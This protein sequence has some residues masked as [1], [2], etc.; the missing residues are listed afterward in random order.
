MQYLDP[1]E[2]W[3]WFVRKTRRVP[4]V[5][6]GIALAEGP[7]GVEVRSSAA[8]TVLLT[9]LGLGL[10]VVGY[11]VWPHERIGAYAALVLGGLFLVGAL[12]GA[13][14]R[15]GVKWDPY[16][17]A[18]TLCRG[19]VPFVRTLELP[20][21][22]LRIELSVGGDDSA[23]SSLKPGYS[24][25]SLG[26]ADRPGLA[27]LAC[28]EERGQLDAVVE[29]LGA[30]LGAPAQDH[31]HV[32]VVTGDGEALEVDA[33]PLGRDAATARSVRLSFLS[34][35]VAVFRS[36]GGG[37][38]RGFLMSG[39]A[40][41]A[42]FA[43][44]TGMPLRSMAPFFIVAVLCGLVAMGLLRATRRT[45]VA[46]LETGLISLGRRGKPLEIRDVAAV[47]TCLSWRSGETNWTLCEVNLVLSRPAGKRVSLVNDPDPEAAKADARR[48]A[49]FLGVPLLDHTSPG[50]D[51]R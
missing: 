1:A 17:R 7:D 19:Y 40:M 8:H 42:V 13:T 43:L 12:L 38:V 33:T 24:L 29:R 4:L 46:D 27:H 32:P 14:F 47:Q 39:L 2:G 48:F 31:T 25:L 9:G 26:Y 15:G 3:D 45:I 11:F 35:R 23:M 10:P 34:P 50:P 6:T 21:D 28:V 51:R 44:A 49:E 22:R 20:K 41:G 5:W 36:E 18:L 16:G 30:F 37:P